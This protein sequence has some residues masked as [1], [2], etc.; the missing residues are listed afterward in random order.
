MES[1]YYRYRKRNFYFN[2]RNSSMINTK[3]IRKHQSYYKRYKYSHSNDRTSPL[4]NSQ[5]TITLR[6][7]VHHYKYY[8]YNQKTPNRFCNRN[9]SRDKDYSKQKN[10][11]HHHHHHH[12]H[13]YNNRDYRKRKYSKSYYYHKFKK[14]ENTSKYSNNHSHEKNEKKTF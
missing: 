2:S 3:R 13:Q 9:R 10:H 6:N 4:N 1:S 5:T 14:L 8:Y 11:H 12:H 7:N